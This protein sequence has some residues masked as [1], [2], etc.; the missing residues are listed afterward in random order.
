[1]ADREALLKRRAELLK[2]RQA[3]A[4]KQT[5]A[6]KAAPKK[7]QSALDYLLEKSGMA[8]FVDAVAEEGRQLNEG[9]QSGLSE[10]VEGMGAARAGGGLGMLIPPDEMIG[11]TAAA[12]GTAAEYAIPTNRLGVVAASAGPV[13]SMAGRGAKA[14]V[15]AGD[16]LKQAN[17]GE[18]A[19]AALVSGKTA[20]PYRQA[21]TMVANSGR[22]PRGNM[23]PQANAAFGAELEKAGGSLGRSAGMKQLLGD[24]F[25]PRSDAPEFGKLKNIVLKAEKALKD[26]K[27]TNE[28]AALARSAAARLEQSVDHAFSAV[29]SKF[30]NMFDDF[31]ETKGAAN[32]KGVARERYVAEVGKS[33][34]Q[35]MPLNQN[36]S[37]N[38]LRL[39]IMTTE[40]LG[41]PAAIYAGQPE[42]A[43]MLGA[44]AGLSSPV[45]MREALKFGLPAA[46]FAAGGASKPSILGFALGADDMGQLT[47]EPKR[48][49]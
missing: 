5:A 35:P 31:L 46:K 21:E 43:A 15:K 19:L 47:G 36:M 23:V 3:L 37:P 4:G 45:V 12:L 33:F 11:G 48:R 25:P 30:K 32:M 26:N 1:M 39:G 41:I 17:Y 10:A 9:I 13:A 38:K 16:K 29:G 8:P 34:S 40:L 7:E 14:A 28:G 44:S 24:P 6:P 18:K 20:V 2:Q 27:L 42:L 49:K 22:I